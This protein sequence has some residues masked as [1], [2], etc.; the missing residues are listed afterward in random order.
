MAVSSTRREA[1]TRRKAEDG[2]TVFRPATA[3]QDSCS[4]V[5]LEPSLNEFEGNG[6]GLP[7]AE[8]DAG[9]AALAAADF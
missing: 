3:T 5:R 7:A 6:H 2:R 1:A 9:D 8:T 4:S